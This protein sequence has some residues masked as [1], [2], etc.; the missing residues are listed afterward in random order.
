M[1]TSY[2]AASTKPTDDELLDLINSL[3]GELGVE[4]DLWYDD[5]DLEQLVGRVSALSDVPRILHAFDRSTPSSW[6]QLVE[7]CS[8]RSSVVL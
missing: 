4:L 1:K 5:D 8:L 3:L 2:P 6:L 7:R